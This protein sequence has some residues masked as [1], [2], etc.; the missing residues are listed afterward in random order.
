MLNH[1]FRMSRD[2]FQKVYSSGVERHSA[3]LFVRISS[4]FGKN[5][6]SVVISKRVLRGAVARH[7]LR[8][9]IYSILRGISP[10]VTQPVDIIVIAKKN[11]GKLSFKE[12][13]KELE[14]LLLL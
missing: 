12:I 8:R 3:H 7:F 10:K 2:F 14:T 6:G 11:I 9:R 4:Q 13:Q 5:K 1:R